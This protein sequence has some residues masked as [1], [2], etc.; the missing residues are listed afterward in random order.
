[1][2]AFGDFFIFSTKPH[3]RDYVFQGLETPRSS[4]QD[5][6]TNLWERFKTALIAWIISYQIAFIAIESDFF[7]DLIRIAHT[8]SADMLPTG[9]V[10]RTWILEARKLK[11]KGK[12]GEDAT[13]S[14]RL[15]S[16][17][18]LQYI[19]YSNRSHKH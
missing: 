6:P 8:G 12:L 9:N 11:V 19:D 1:M 4:T 17:L 10:I 15:L 3:D 2:T 18:D 16:D 5:I 14:A 7:K 13:I